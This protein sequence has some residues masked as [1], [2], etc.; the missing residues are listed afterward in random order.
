MIRI[1]PKGLA[2]RV[3][4]VMVFCI[5]SYNG[6]GYNL[7]TLV[8]ENIGVSPW[9]VAFGGLLWAAALVFLALVMRD[10]LGVLG[11]VFLVLI[12]SA[13]GGW[14]WNAGLLDLTSV[15]IWE[16][17]LPILLGLALSV[18]LVGGFLYRMATGRIM[19]EDEG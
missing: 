16:W 18:G 1:T 4:F 6:S 2:F 14:A 11:I 9:P 13:G 12:F 7:Y 5:G 3:L 15:S 8:F 17:G 19:V 10:T